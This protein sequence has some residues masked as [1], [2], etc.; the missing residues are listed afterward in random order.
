M[1]SEPTN[2]IACAVFKPVLDQLALK[3][4][5]PHLRVTFLP[6][7]LHVNPAKLYDYVHWVTLLCRQRGERIV[8]LYG[9]CF[10]DFCGFS[11]RHNARKVNGT[12]C[13]EILLGTEQ[14]RRIMD[15]TAGTYF[16]ERS[17]IEDFEKCCA[18]PLELHDREMR[19][20]IF[21]HYR[22][23][24]YVRQSSDPDLI[25]RVSRL[26]DFLE[27]DLEIRDADYSHIERELTDLIESS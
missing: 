15:E 19:E 8:F 1:S 18:E 16:L 4:R 7:N 23:L 27:L 21:N 22:R 5:F 17:L 9:E 25:P 14:F 3:L 2:I 6:A 12:S 13:Y 20:C 11:E 24:I 26:A 10:P